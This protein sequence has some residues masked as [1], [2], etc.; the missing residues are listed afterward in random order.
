V[1]D[2]TV[3][4]QDLEPDNDIENQDDESDNSTSGSVLPSISLNSHDI[5]GDGR[6]E[7]E[8]YESQLEEEGEHLLHKLSTSAVRFCV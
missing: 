2:R 4:F 1:E 5:V 7:G 8:G 3:G 6:R